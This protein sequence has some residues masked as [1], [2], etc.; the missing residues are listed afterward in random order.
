M[1]RLAKEVVLVAL[2]YVSTPAY[3]GERY[4]EPIKAQPVSADA[5]ALAFAGAKALAGASAV[6]NPVVTAAGGAGGAGGSATGGAG[7][8]AVEY[9]NRALALGLDVADAPEV[10]THRCLTV[11]PMT[12]VL[13]SG[14]GGRTE[15]DPQCMCMERVTMYV[16]LGRKDLALKQMSSPQCGG[17]NV[18]EEQPEPAQT[19]YAT[20]PLE[21]V[22]KQELNDGLDRVFEACQ[23]K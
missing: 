12:F 16:E 2:V 11:T 20:P 6:S 18:P 4:Q 14:R 8:G 13:G 5:D 15:L 19:V 1:N 9:S 10:G 17:I 3:G 7:V 22:D 21:C 23:S